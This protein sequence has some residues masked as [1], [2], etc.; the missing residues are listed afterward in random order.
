MELSRVYANENVLNTLTSMISSGRLC[1][2]FL[3]FGEKGLGKKTIARFCAQKILC[4]GDGETPCMRCKACKMILHGT[5]PDVVHISHNEDSKG[6]RIDNIRKICAD[7]FIKPNEGEYKIYIFEDCDNMPPLSQNAL[8]KLIEEPPAHAVF[9]FTASSKGMLLP[10]VISR[11][12]S[13]GVCGVSKEQCF[14]ALSDSGAFDASQIEQAAE[15]FGSNIGMCLEYLN[16]KEL[17]AAVL[18]AREIS[19]K[20]LSDE[21]SLL[22]SVCFIGKDKQL[23]KTVLGLMAGIIR[24]AVSVKLECE[25]LIGC[26]TS[27]SER[28]SARLTLRQADELFRLL[29]ETSQRLDGNA[30]MPLTLS[31]LCSGIKSIV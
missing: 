6:F 25:T 31:A 4:E 28:L 30:S 10:T 11:V 24:D 1:H 8:L 2:A 20:I 17:K 23:L 7:A 16:G 5:H 15:V 9:I 26:Y 22:R 18:A 13:L 14:Q 21:Y 27:G 12:I 29:G 3:L 19:D